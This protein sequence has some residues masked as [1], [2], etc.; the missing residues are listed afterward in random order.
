MKPLTAEEIAELRRAHSGVIAEAWTLADA[1]VTICRENATLLL[2]ANNILPRLLDEVERSRGTDH[3]EREPTNLGATALDTL[4][5]APFTPGG[6]FL[7]PRA[8]NQIHDE[9]EHSRALLKRIESR[10]RALHADGYPDFFADGCPECG[11]AKPGHC[12][13]SCELAALIGGG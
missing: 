2:A 13:E 11:A 1:P 4:N 10:G 3:P 9:L 6:R 8:Y 7:H 5:R 12:K